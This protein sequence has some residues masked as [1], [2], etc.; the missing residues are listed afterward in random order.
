[1]TFLENLNWRYAAK[2]FGPECIE[3]EKINKI[4]DAIRLAPSSFGV[5]PYHIIIIKDK[6]N[7]QNLKKFVKNDE[8]NIDEGKLEELKKFARNNEKKLESCEY[9]FVFCARTDVFSRF[10][11]LE[12]MQ[13]RPKYSMWKLGIFFQYFS[14][15]GSY[16]I[17]GQWF[18]TFSWA[19]RQ[20]YV[21]LGFALAACAELG[22]DSCPMEGFNS[23]KFAK[24][25]KLPRHI[26]PVVILAVGS[27]DEN[28]TGLKYPKTRF[29]NEDLFSEI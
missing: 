16:I 6:N 24:V 23:S 1:M 25:L 12:E 21:A 19:T 26:K 29:S 27:R 28:D 9:L 13:K 5:Q 8:K 17:L 2:N 22:V 11:K 7:L 10:K 14:F 3:D 4:K 18:T 20:A 15:L